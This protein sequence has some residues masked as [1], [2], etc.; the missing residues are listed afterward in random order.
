MTRALATRLKRLERRARRAKPRGPIVY[1]IYPEEVDGAPIIAL[2]ARGHAINRRFDELDWQAFL[3]RAHNELGRPFIVRAIYPARGPLG[4]V[5]GSP[6][7]SAAPA[8]P[9]GFPW[10]LAGIGRTATH[11]ELRRM[12]AVSRIPEDIADTP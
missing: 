4:A 8:P 5:V 10:Q 7:E 2:Q 12:G 9:A 11:Q 3:D 1:G 6:G